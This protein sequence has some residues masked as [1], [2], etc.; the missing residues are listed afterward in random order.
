MRRKEERRR[1]ERDRERER[2]RERRG[3]REGH[4]DTGVACTRILSG[5]PSPLSK[6]PRPGL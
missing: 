5:S 2:E 6:N 1:E 4:K 3:R